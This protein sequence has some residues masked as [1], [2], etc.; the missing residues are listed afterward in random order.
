LQYSQTQ[1]R[2]TS[3]F[4]SMA[5]AFG[6]LGGD[7]STL[8]QN[9][10]GI[11]VYRSSDVN[12]TIGL[13]FNSA[14]T[15]D[16]KT[17]DTKFMFN[18]LGYVGAIKLDSETMPNL[19][20]G[21][22]YNRLNSFHRHYTGYLSGI[23]TSVTNYFAEKA[24]QDGM[25]G[26]D[27]A[28]TS[29][30]NPFWD[31]PAR[32]DQIAA[33]QTYLI[34]PTNPQRNQF[35]GLGYD[36]V[37]GDAEFEI[38]ED[39]HTDE[40]N[41]ALG[42]NIHNKVYWGFDMGITDLE[43]NSYKYYGEA[44]ENTVFP[45]QTES[46]YN[47]DGNAALGIVNESRTVGTGVNFK[48]GVIVKPINELRFGIAFHTP[49]YYSMKD[50]YTG[51]ISS[52][53][54]SEAF[55]S[56]TKTNLSEYPWNDVRYEIRTPW[57][58]I[59]SVATVIGGKAILSA[60]YEYTANQDMKIKDDY[61]YELP[62]ATNEIKSYLQ[63]SHNIRI[64]AEYRVTPNFSLRAGYSYQTS[65]TKDVVKNDEIDV[66]VSGTNPAYNYD[67]SIQHITA[68]FGYHYKS[69]YLDMAYVNQCRKGNY[70]AFSG[71][72]DLPTVG[73]EVKDNNNRVT[74]TIGFR[75]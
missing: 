56:E 9:P 23:P 34:N 19:N 48:F 15:T 51:N 29:G 52:D 21:L 8:G 46:E 6:A 49:T 24:M 25:T 71:I 1:L 68:G 44:L 12:A 22:S 26:V 11:G 65:P 40:Y 28:S 43:Y 66:E 50:T 39:G 62:D 3:R 67:N 30:Y 74:A 64:G 18:N 17:T 60:D 73:A 20:W 41:I 10:A 63:A 69:F 2:G 72:E 55:G 75:F 42:G 7:I 47:V 53:F 13:D 61:G 33:F 38:I 35:S 31:G 16:I 54:A 37:Y 32:W 27:L 36:G 4:N 45:D 70:H 5:G 59:G 58:F 14:T 57:H